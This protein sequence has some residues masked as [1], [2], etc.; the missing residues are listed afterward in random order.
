MSAT[1]DQVHQLD[2]N[3]LVTAGCNEDSQA[4][5]KSVDFVSFHHYG[6]VANLKARI[7]ALRAVSQKPILLG[8][9]GYSTLGGDETER[10]T[11]LQKALAA[12]D[13][14]G[15]VGWMIWTAFDF[16]TDV[17]CLPPACPSKEN[18]EH[19]FG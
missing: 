16:S 11:L 7:A 2:P 1:I 4:T 18:G 14:S 15:V 12:A 6:T 17:T 19:H 9:I 5:E 13:A 10:G 8:E 3:H